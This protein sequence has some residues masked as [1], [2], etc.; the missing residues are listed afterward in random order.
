MKSL[1]PFYLVACATAVT[2]CAFSVLLSILMVSS[3]FGV[4]AASPLDRPEIDRL[5]A[6]LQAHPTNIVA[7]DQ[8]RNCDLAARRAY[9]GGLAS[10][11]TGGYLLLG[12]LV[13]A[14]LS[15]KAVA[16]C[17]RRRPDPRQYPPPEDT[18]AAAAAMRFTLAATFLAL[19][20]GAVAL[21]LKA[22]LGAETSSSPAVGQRAVRPG[23]AAQPG[24]D[25]RAAGLEARGNWP[26]FRGPSGSGV[27]P[28]TNLPA[29]WDGP[30][31]A[32]I[33]WKV[34]VPL[35]GRS[36]PVVW[37]NRV[38]LTGATREKR[39]VYCF[40]IA[41]GAL[42]W[43][44]PVDSG[45]GEAIDV[46][47]DTG[48]A[49]PTPVV[50]GT[51]VYAIFANGDVAALGFCA[52]KRWTVNLGKPVNQYG[53]ASS[54]A[55]G[56]DMIFIQFDNNVERGGFSEL[57]A[58]DKVTG[59]EVWKVDRTV[60]DS[61]ASPIVIEPG[62]GPQLLTAANE[63]I[64]AYQPGSGEEIWKV[65]CKGSDSVPSPLF[66][67]GLV[68]VPVANDQVYAIKPDGKGD[69]SQAGVAWTFSE[70]VSDVPSPVSNGELVYLL[71]SSGK[72]TCCDV[73]SGKKVWEQ[74]IAESF[75]ASPVM[76]GDR[77]FLVARSGAI[78][79][80]K[81]G[82]K[83]EELG[84]ASLGEPSDSTPALAPGLIIMRG[85]S[86]LFCIGS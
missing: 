40:D 56:Q 43:Q 84:R 79:I 44:A 45:V 66:A 68:I 59:K 35:P 29:A 24:A 17:R 7:Q 12:G 9:F 36:S 6:E 60:A 25:R 23:P 50:D 42:L 19:L 49:A 85:A 11:R 16:A 48:Y 22:R 1:R 32:G 18:L 14:L 61:W 28:Y 55:I 37:G 26:G 78:F 5:R 4:R 57:I 46:N 34:P 8:I 54:P 21:G 73:K 47:E 39:E 63:W 41:T 65:G 82:P 75:F 30:S 69:V 83:Y 27:G 86:N 3:L 2:A 71:F 64:I 52:E 80:L 77:L 13:V 15:L 81:A 76:A 72:L 70:N 33:K 67:G 20:A 31:G 51:N 62:A 74:D 38:F 58:L 53:F 10:L